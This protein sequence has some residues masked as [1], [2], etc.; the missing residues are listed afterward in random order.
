M[1]GR[2]NKENCAEAARQR[3][4][5]ARYTCIRRARE[6]RAD[7]RQSEQ[8]WKASAS[9]AKPLSVHVASRPCGRDRPALDQAM[10]E[11]NA[12]GL[13]SVPDI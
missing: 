13:A 3:A 4:E 1:T 8:L 7:Q 5:L 6:R 11:Q 12:L 9:S 2:A 10:R